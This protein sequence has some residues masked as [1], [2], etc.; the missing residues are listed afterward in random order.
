[1]NTDRSKKVA[2]VTGSSSSIGFEISLLLARNGFLLM[3][4]CAIL[5][6][7]KFNRNSHY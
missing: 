1:M 6:N 5:K 2:V 7:P 4:Q 3:L